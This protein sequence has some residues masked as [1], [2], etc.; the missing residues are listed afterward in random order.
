MQ[1]PDPTRHSIAPLS[2]DYDLVRH[3]YAGMLQSLR[4]L[5]ETCYRVGRLE[6]AVTVLQNSLPYL[7]APDVAPSDVIQTLLQL[8]RMQII[9]YT[10]L[11]R[12]DELLRPTLLR[13]KTL[14]DSLG[15]ASS[16]ATALQL[17]GEASYYRLLWTN[18]GNVE[19]TDIQTYFQQA[20]ELRERLNDLR[21]LSETWR[22]NGLIAERQRLSDLALSYFQRSLHY[23]QQ[24]K[25]PIDEAEALRHLGGFA[26]ARY[27][28]DTAES[29]LSHSL[30]LRQALGYRILLP[31][32]Q[33]AVGY[34]YEARRELKHAFSLYTLANKLSSEMSLLHSEVFSLLSMGD[35]CKIQGNI[36][37]ALGYYE[38]AY[39]IAESYDFQSGLLAANSRLSELSHSTSTD[40]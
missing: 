31:A 12:D 17:L 22:F 6:E 37:Q 28:Y 19:I 7:E 40:Q 4:A 29:Y 8:G 13:A 35:V 39:N 18:E 36:T 32:A 27:D 21:G 1:T 10:Y 15:D 14:A 26:L 25:S 30:S 38:Q 24:A 5:S 11:L 16:I 33:L 3:Y 23:A 34:V 2:A 9:R 20:R